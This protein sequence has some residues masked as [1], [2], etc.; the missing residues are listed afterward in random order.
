MPQ[1]GPPFGPAIWRPEEG[2]VWDAGPGTWLLEP[3]LWVPV[4]RV[5][6][7]RLSRHIRAWGWWVED[8]E[9]PVYPQRGFAEVNFHG[10]DTYIYWWVDENLLYDMTDAVSRGR[11]FRE[12]IVGRYQYYQVG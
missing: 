6:R 9:S 7:I 11:W 10:G 2:F 3:G 5:Y 4:R 8:E 1:S 12:H